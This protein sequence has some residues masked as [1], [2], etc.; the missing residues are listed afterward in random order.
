MEREQQG[1]RG[2]GLDSAS[3]CGSCELHLLRHLGSWGHQLRRAHELRSAIKV[4]VV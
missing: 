4:S 2:G 3:F 1:G